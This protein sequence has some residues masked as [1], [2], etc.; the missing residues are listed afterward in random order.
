MLKKNSRVQFTLTA[1]VYPNRKLWILMTVEKNV[2]T[3]TSPLEYKAP[4]TKLSVFSAVICRTLTEE[5]VAFSGEWKQR[6]GMYHLL[7]VKLK[8][9][10]RLNSESA[11]SGLPPPL[12]DLVVKLDNLPRKK[13]QIFWICTNLNR[14]IRKTLRPI[15]I[16]FFR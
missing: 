13:C 1:K 8:P 15:I 2:L 6:S 16:D 4:S 9:N 7:A 10:F 14:K 12:N 5:I 3:L 11:P